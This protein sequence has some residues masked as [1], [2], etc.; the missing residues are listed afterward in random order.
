MEISPGFNLSCFKSEIPNPGPKASL[1]KVAKFFH[2]FSS[3]YVS[4]P[5]HDENLTRLR[6]RCHCVG[7]NPGST[8]RLIKNG[9]RKLPLLGNRTGSEK[10][11]LRVGIAIDCI[12]NTPEPIFAK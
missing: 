3:R 12:F 8:L 10:Y 4:I 2:D 5:K 11:S 6:A 7:R 1:A 9:R